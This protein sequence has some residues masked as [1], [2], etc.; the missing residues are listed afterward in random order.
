MWFEFPIEEADIPEDE[1]LI[2]QL[3]DRRFDLDNKSRRKVEPKSKFKERNGKSPDKADALLLCFYNK[4]NS[5]TLDDK[6]KKALR[7]R[8]RKR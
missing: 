8:N 2:D 1:E 6:A 7:N 5:F 3:A 4:K